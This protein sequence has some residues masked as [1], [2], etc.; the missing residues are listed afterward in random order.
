MNPALLPP[1][2]VTL[3]DLFPLCLVVDAGFGENFSYRH[4]RLLAR[5]LAFASMILL[6]VTR[7][8][9]VGWDITWKCKNGLIRL[10]SSQIEAG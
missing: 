3:I 8:P 6:T 10:I 4:V 1:D 2:W 7:V 9:L 5:L